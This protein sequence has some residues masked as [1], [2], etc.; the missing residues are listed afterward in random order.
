MLIQFNF[1]NYKSFKNDNSLD[2]TATKISEHNNRVVSIANDRLLRIAAIYGANAGGKSNVHDAFRFMSKYVLQSFA[3]GGERANKKR[4]QLP[5]KP[6]MFDKI[7]Q[8]EKSTFEVFFIDQTDSSLK[9]YQYG[10]SLKGAIVAEEWLYYKSKTARRDYKTIF[11]RDADNN[12][13]DFEKIT[14]KQ[15]ENIKTSLEPETLIVSL[16][17]KL[18]IPSLKMVYNWFSN[19]EAI[20]FSNDFESLFRLN[21]LPDGFV[22]DINVQDRVVQFFNSFDESI[23]GFDINKIIIEDDDDDKEKYIINA[24]HKIINSDEVAVIPLQDESKGTLEMFS[25]FPYMQ[26]V[27]QKGSV[28]FVDELNTKLHPLLVRNIILT[29]ANPEINTKN[30]QLIFT[31]HDSWQLSNNLLRRDEIWFTEKDANGISSL[32]SLADFVDEA[33][34]KIRKDESYEKNYLLGKYGAIPSLKTIDFLREE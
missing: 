22:E 20:D 33:G 32:Y 16:G 24:K 3:F 9:S 27:L 12:K 14:E 30:A 4:R 18:K 6:F 11:Y 10:F 13:L 31:A 25:L 29:F 28:L 23:I 15:S 5:V 26:D 1:E 34:V 21:M 19:N 2:L 17:A 8:K 7:S